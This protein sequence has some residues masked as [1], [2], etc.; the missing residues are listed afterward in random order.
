M[1]II[2]AVLI[3]CKF[4]CGVIAIAMG[5]AANDPHLFAFG[6]GHAFIL[7]PLWILTETT[8]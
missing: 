7:S 6:I 3:A 8:A 2:P 1:N 5:M 4:T